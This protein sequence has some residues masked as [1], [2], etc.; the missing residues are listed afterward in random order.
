MTLN[1]RLGRSATHAS[2]L[3]ALDLFGRGRSQSISGAAT[4]VDVRYPRR[5][6]RDTTKPFVLEPS[7]WTRRIGWGVVLR[8]RLADPESAID[9]LAAYVFRGTPAANQ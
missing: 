3:L 8:G 5:H 4:H 2:A 9:M 1:S 7:V 6:R